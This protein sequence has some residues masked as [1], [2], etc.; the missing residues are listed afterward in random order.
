MHILFAIIGI[1]TALSVWYWRAQ[2]AA[3]AAKDAR[4]L[5]KTA[6]NLP[7]KLAFQHKAARAG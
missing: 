1:V 2:A 6:A 3:R 7:R 5:A 4:E